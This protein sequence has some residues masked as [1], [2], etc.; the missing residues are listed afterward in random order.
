MAPK[1]LEAAQPPARATACASATQRHLS[2]AVRLLPSSAATSCWRS[3][4]CLVRASRA[5]IT[6]S[7]LSLVARRSESYAGGVAADELRPDV[8]TVTDPPASNQPTGK[9]SLR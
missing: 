1:A 9:W 7:C 8:Q 2:P 6:R 4:C 3:T 5:R